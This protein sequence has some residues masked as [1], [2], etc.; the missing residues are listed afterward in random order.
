MVVAA[1][2]VAI[3]AA[4]FRIMFI[5]HP[6]VITVGCATGAMVQKFLK[7]FRAWAG[8]FALGLIKLILLGFR[9][10]LRPHPEERR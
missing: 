1:M 10:L 3:A 8:T 2:S 6:I 5:A 4:V 9:L 7:L